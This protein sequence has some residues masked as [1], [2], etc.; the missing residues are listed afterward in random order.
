[1]SQKRKIQREKFAE[2]QQ[3]KA[4][5]IIKIIIGALVIAAAAYFAFYCVIF[6]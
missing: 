2:K 1:M 5:K 3:H 4:E 6:S